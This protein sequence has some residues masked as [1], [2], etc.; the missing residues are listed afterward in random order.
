MQMGYDFEN[1]RQSAI[2]PVRIGQA[3][4]PWGGAG[5]AG[6]G[7]GGGIS[8][9]Q[10]DWAA[11][12]ARFL[13]VHGLRRALDANGSA[14]VP[15][16]SFAATAAAVLLDCRQVSSGINRV[17]SGNRKAAFAINHVAAASLTAGDRGI[18]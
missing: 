12:R 6:A 1:E 9:A 13:A 10:P 2:Q 7:G 5:D 18:L 16:G 3:G 15:A 8:H 11:L 4:L 14:V 17:Y